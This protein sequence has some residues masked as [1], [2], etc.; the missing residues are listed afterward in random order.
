MPSRVRIVVRTRPTSNA[1]NDFRILSNDTLCVTR[2]LPSAAGVPTLAPSLSAGQETLTVHAD[3]VLHNA[4]QE[5]TYEM[6]AAELVESVLQGV[7]CTLLCYGQSGSGKTYTLFGGEAYPTRGCVPR[8]IHSLFDTTATMTEREFKVAITF[9]E[10]QG[11]QLVDL[12]GR[13]SA[14]AGSFST[15]HKAKNSNVSKA[16]VFID[17]TGNVVLRGVEKRECYSEE[18]ALAAVFEGLQRRLCGTG[19]HSPHRSRSHALLTLYVV[20]KSLVDSDAVTHHSRCNFV[21]LAGSDCPHSLNDEVAQQESKVIN[22]SLMMLEQVVFALS[23]TRNRHVP[24]RQS[25]LTMLLKDSIGGDCKTTLVANIWPEQRNME[26]TFGTLN[27]AKRMARIE[28]NPTLHFS[29][30]PQA[31]IRLLQRQ[32]NSLKSEL[33]MQDQLAGR[34]AVGAAPLESDEIQIARERVMAFVDGMTP[35][36]RVDCVRDMNACFLAFKTLLCERDAQLQEMGRQ[37]NMANRTDSPASVRGLSR[38]RGSL[39]HTGSLEKK[40]ETTI[41]SS[42]VDGTSGVGVGTTDKPSLGLRDMLPQQSSHRFVSQITQNVSK[43]K[44]TDDMTIS[45]PSPTGAMEQVALAATSVTATAAPA[46][47][48]AVQKKLAPSLEEEGLQ[49]RLRNQMH[50]HSVK[51]AGGKPDAILSSFDRTSALP[52][53]AMPLKR[54]EG[55]FRDKRVA[56]ESYK[57]TTAGVSQLE[58]IKN[59]QRLVEEKS[60]LILELQKRVNDI[61]ADMGAC[62]QSGQTAERVT[63]T[64]TTHGASNEAAGSSL[65]LSE[66]T[67][68]SWINNAVSNEKFLVTPA[69]DFRNMTTVEKKA[70]LNL[71]VDAVTRAVTERSILMNQLNRR[72]EAFMNNFHYWYSAQL[73]PGAPQQGERAAVGAADVERTSVLKAPVQIPPNSLRVVGQQSE[74]DQRFIDS[75]ERFEDMEMRRRVQKDPESVK[76]YA[77]QRLVRRGQ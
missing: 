60:K 40:E 19:T 37:S 63:T 49:E 73:Q 67:S 42:V 34:E 43:N 55:D 35:Q 25:K 70:F 62:K 6:A 23:G 61:K 29:M 32:V 18:E 30:D 52:T 64:T 57:W 65:W 33:R 71:A 4:S 51:E 9:V 13:G 10:I 16:S 38:R 8:V 21:D 44:N 56:F 68:S 75:G 47:L 24:Y 76:F 58:S 22:R 69:E 20:S 12:L 59:A 3:A 36:L 11:E 15:R 39:R 50:T 45:T 1:T 17:N 41:L 53:V 5:A 66:S 77:A 27:F 48:P 2:Q 31:Q 26:A 14:L 54:P 72:Y 7:N 46:T 74:Y 28:S